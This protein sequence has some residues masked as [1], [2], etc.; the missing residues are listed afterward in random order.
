MLSKKALIMDKKDNVAT[1]TSDAN[2]GDFVE[3]ISKTGNA[4]IRVK[5]RDQI[6]F[7]HKVSLASIEKN[8]KIIKYG[9]I[10]GVSSKSI[11]K[12]EHVHVHN[13]KSLKV[14]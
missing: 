12:G 9:K 4:E 13:V 3:V 5:A 1:L 11:K 7:G 10:I 14:R 2:L 6:P 8:G